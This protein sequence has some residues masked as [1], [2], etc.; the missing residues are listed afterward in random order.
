MCRVADVH[1]VFFWVAKEEGQGTLNI[2]WRGNTH[3]LKSRP[4]KYALQ[5]TGLLCQMSFYHNDDSFISH[6]KVRNSTRYFM[7]L[8]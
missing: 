1:W 6:M 5:T 4:G 7:V 8:L 3:E 2:R